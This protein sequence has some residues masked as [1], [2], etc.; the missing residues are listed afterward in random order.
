MANGNISFTGSANLLLRGQTN[1]NVEKRDSIAINSMDNLLDER[2]QSQDSFGRWINEVI[3]E[4]PGSV[5]DPAIE[6]SI[7]SVHN[8]YRD[9][10]L[11]HSQTLA[12]E[13][14][15]NITEVSPAWA[16]STEKTKVS[17]FTS[18]NSSQFLYLSYITSPSYFGCFRLL[19]V[20]SCAGKEHI[21]FYVTLLNPILV[22][23]LFCSVKF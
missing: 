3:I 4:S 18:T 13:Q 23:A 8:S 19:S 2:L 9:S 12:M 11:Y 22:L 5:I 21:P 1:L 20:S 14:I 10:T 7:S 16:L 15:F 17:S 6:P